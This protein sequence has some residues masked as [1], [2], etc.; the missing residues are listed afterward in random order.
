MTYKPYIKPFLLAIL[1]LG[2]VHLC[3]PI[4]AAPEA[5]PQGDFSKPVDPAKG[6]GPLKDGNYDGSAEGYNGMMNM[7]VT[8]QS[9]WISG[10][11]ITGTNDDKEYLDKAKDQVLNDVLEKQ[12]TAEVE[13]V[14]GATF[15][16]Y[17]MLDAIDDAL[18]KAG[19]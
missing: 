3:S 10:L 4:S 15:S 11:S 13:A 17:G 14:S 16:S 18:M 5:I 6:K 19:R 2:A 8:V 7:K 1:L 12:N 9:G